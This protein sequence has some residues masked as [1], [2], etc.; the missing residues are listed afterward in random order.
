[1]RQLYLGRRTSYPSDIIL[2]VHPKGRNRERLIRALQKIRA[3]SPAVARQELELIHTRNVGHPVAQT[4]I[5]AGFFP[6]KIVGKGVVVGKEIPGRTHPELFVR[7]GV[8]FESLVTDVRPVRTELMGKWKKTPL[9]I[10]PVRQENLPSS[11]WL[12]GPSSAISHLS[13]S[14]KIFFQGF[15]SMIPILA[16]AGLLKTIPIRISDYEKCRTRNNPFRV[17]GRFLE[18]SDKP[19]HFSKFSLLAG[20]K[21]SIKDLPNAIKGKKVG[22]RGEDL[23]L[24][25]LILKHRGIQCQLMSVVNPEAAVRDKKV[26]FAFAHV[27]SGE[28]ARSHNL[29]WVPLFYSSQ[30]AVVH[31]DALKNEKV[32]K[33]L[34]E[35]RKKH[36][37]Y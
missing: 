36:I 10:I 20:N 1:M 29:N 13:R 3:L 8:D 14:S 31:K 30:V 5:K 28:T 32:G 18:V 2:S 12:E 22:V 11:M 23:L 24:A 35:L 26:D 34:A 37:L 6:G 33:F 15:D 27:T 17:V 16:N 4:L 7:G 9:R 25:E 21:I 19:Q